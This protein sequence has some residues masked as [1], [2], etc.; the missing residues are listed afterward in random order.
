MKNRNKQAILLSISAGLMVITARYIRSEENRHPKADQVVAQLE[1]QVAN[2]SNPQAATVTLQVCQDGNQIGLKDNHPCLGPN[3]EYAVKTVID[4][5]NQLKDAA[6]NLAI[7]KELIEK[8][9]K[10][11]RS[12][13]K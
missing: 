6:E 11:C 1:K 8:E 5:F 9:L 7:E 10:L 4:Q 13:R 12:A 3:P 2:Q